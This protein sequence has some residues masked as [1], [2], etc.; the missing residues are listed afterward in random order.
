MGRNQRPGSEFFSYDITGRPDEQEAVIRRQG[1]TCRILQATLC[2]CNAGGKPDLYCTLCHGKGFQYRFQ[3]EMTVLEENSEHGGI[4]G[5]PID[6]VYPWWEP[7]VAVD[8]VQFFITEVQ[9]GSFDYNVVSFD[10]TSILISPPAGRKLPLRH[11]PLKVSYRYRM[12][13]RIAGENSRHDGSWT[14]WPNALEINTQRTSNPFQIF[15]DIS[16]VT[17][18]KNLTQ[19]ITYSVGGFNK[20][21]IYL[22]PRANPAEAPQPTDVL[23]VDYERVMPSAVAIMQIETRR[24]MERWGPDFKVGD[25]EGVFAGGWRVSKG[26]VVTIL[27]SSV[28]Y[29]A[30]IKRGD[31]AYDELPAFDVREV[32]GDITDVDGN[33]YVNGTHFAVRDYNNLTWL[34]STKPA[35]GKNY[36]VQF[37]Y[38]M[39]FRVWN[40]DSRVNYSENKRFPQRV[41]MREFSKLDHRDIRT[42]Q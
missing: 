14:V 12:A 18:V 3:A 34:G 8:R 16:A 2:P 29:D 27:G 21:S 28:R 9:G 24:A 32:V 7:I 15:G 36:A 33:R 22:T 26:D 6:R 20:Q 13:D 11:E 10:D 23:E 38:R 1:Q 42:D 39:T 37:L 19:G 17:K 35:L 40:T 41:Q 31:G 30:V 25:V 5:R 4:N